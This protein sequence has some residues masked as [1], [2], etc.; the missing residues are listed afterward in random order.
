[1]IRSTVLLSCIS[2]I[3]LGS[4]SFAEEPTRLDEAKAQMVAKLCAEAESKAKKPAPLKISP[5]VKF[6]TGL[7][8]KKRAALIVPTANLAVATLVKADKEVVPV[9]VLYMLRVTP[10]VI[11]EPLGADRLR[12]F[13]IK[14]DDGKPEVTVAAIQLAVTKVAGRLVLLA[15]TDGKEPV[16]VTT[17]AESQA[18][19]EVP[20]DL[21]AASAGEGRGVLI[22]RMFGKYRGAITIAALD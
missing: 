20:L 6:A 22:V 2:I 13:E 11:D 19:N 14:P 17:L 7:D 9:G 8:L 1:M 3:C 15:Y 4:A 18:G 10:V 5:E 21:E 16:L 12:T